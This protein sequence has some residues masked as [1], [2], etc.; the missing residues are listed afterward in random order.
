[1]RAVIRRGGQTDA[2]FIGYSDDEER[3][4]TDVASGLVVRR[5]C[6]LSDDDDDRSVT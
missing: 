1:M 5:G 2:W 6:S 3:Y 4:A